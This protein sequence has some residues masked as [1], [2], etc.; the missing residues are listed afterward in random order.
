VLRQSI[1]MSR[2]AFVATLNMVGSDAK[3]IATGAAAGAIAVPSLALS[4]YDPRGLWGGCLRRWRLLRLHTEWPRLPCRYLLVKHGKKARP[5]ILSLFSR[6]GKMVWGIIAEFFDMASDYV[7]FDGIQR[8]YSGIDAA[9][10]KVV[11]IYI[12]AL[13]SMI[14][15]T[16]ISFAALSVRCV[17][18]IKQIRRRRREFKAFG[19]R[20]IYS[21]QLC[22]KIQDAERLCK[23]VSLPVRRCA[24]LCRPNSR[25]LRA[26]Q[27]YIGVALA[28]FE[29]A[30]MGAIGMY[31]LISKYSIPT[32]QI[33]SLFSS[34]LLLGM[35]ISALTTLP[36]WWNKLKK[37]RAA[38]HPV[39]VE[40]LEVELTTI[41]HAH[42]SNSPFCASLHELRAHTLEVAQMAER[43]TTSSNRNSMTTVETL[44]MKMAHHLSQSITVAY[45]AD[46]TQSTVP[47][48]STSHHCLAG[49]PTFRSRA[50]CMNTPFRPWVVCLQSNGID[51]S[52]PP[53]ADV[54]R[55]Q[56]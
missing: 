45:A 43:Y 53:R 29:C 41:D 31:F 55:G 23:Q 40:S 11:P 10:A 36:Y 35:K 15:S 30:P 14:L 26:M 21:Q 5:I 48:S 2:T 22:D 3:M 52:D 24:E 12:P 33:V 54:L 46:D 37:W 38:V 4:M 56:C 19:Q 7:M 27:L 50:S 18:A 25:G 39:A 17:I 44:L 8:D 9:R 20:P 51:V 16:A 6:E 13:V 47:V 34:A 42:N 32:F 28:L 49:S 1:N